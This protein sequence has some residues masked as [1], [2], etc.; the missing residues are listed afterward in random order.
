MH[1]KLVI[2]EQF[3]KVL[4]AYR[5]NVKGFSQREMAQM[6]NMK[7]QNYSALESNPTSVSFGRILEVIDRLG[8]VLHIADEALQPKKNKLSEPKQ[9]IFN[10]V[11][12]STNDIG[13]RAAYSTYPP[14][15]FEL[16]TLSKW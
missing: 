3:S 8:L 10:K 13:K 15:G 14:A 9:N 6:L 12:C 4:A 7:Q 5:K 2:V 16:K 1:H 11:S